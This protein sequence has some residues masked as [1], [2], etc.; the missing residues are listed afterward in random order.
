MGFHD[1]LSELLAEVLERV[2]LGVAVGAAIC[3]IEHLKTTVD[4]A[5]VLDRGTEHAG[6]FVAQVLADGFIEAWLFLDVG[7]EEADAFM[8]TESGDAFFHGNAMVFDLFGAGASCGG[9][10]EFTAI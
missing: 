8:C 10:E 6:D 5:L 1:H 3:G 9:E 7:D 2:E 4:T